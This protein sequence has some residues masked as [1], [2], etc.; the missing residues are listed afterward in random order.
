[1]PLLHS[2]RP[3]LPTPQ[4]LEPLAAA[5]RAELLALKQA[6][7]ASRSLE[8][9]GLI[10]PYDFQYYCNQRVEKAFEVDNEAIKRYFPLEVVTKGLL[11]IYQGLLGLKFV[12]VPNA[13]VW[14][15]DVSMYQVRNRPPQLAH[16]PF[17]SLA[18]L[19]VFLCD[20]PVPR[21]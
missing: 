3:I 16:V 8:F 12:Q 6:E 20:L 14:H 21:R 4:L 1:L 10:H 18:D 19:C 5:E 11:D 9:D 17:S 15:E 7:C 2:F 13:H